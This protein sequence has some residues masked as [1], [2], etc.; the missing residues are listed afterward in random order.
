[1]KK[2]SI[3][4]LLVATA[5]VGCGD[6][7][8]GG[9]DPLPIN[10]VEVYLSLDRSGDYAAACFE[11]PPNGEKPERVWQDGPDTMFGIDGLYTSSNGSIRIV[12]EEERRIDCQIYTGS[13]TYAVDGAFPDHKK[14]VEPVKIR[15]K[16]YSAITITEDF[17]VDNGNGG[18]NFSFRA[19]KNGTIVA[20]T[21][22]SSDDSGGPGGGSG[23][24]TVRVR[25]CGCDRPSTESALLYGELSD[26]FGWN[27]GGQSMN[28]NT[29]SQCF[30]ITIP[31]VNLNLSGKRCGGGDGGTCFTFNATYNG[32]WG[33]VGYNPYIRFGCQY[34]VRV[35]TGSWIT[36][37]TT[38][39]NTSGGRNLQVEISPSGEINISP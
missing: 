13:G 4:S 36:D 20:G 34:S 7:A 14:I 6:R 16:G 29:T 3:F 8:S 12:V 33:V 22:P 30:E 37:T 18:T 10:G 39:T 5:L 38:V 28:Y 24:A 11:N 35:N 23:S 17:L 31:N 1:M 21:T 32:A 9:V 15:V 2:S 26:S 19:H 25:S 27:D